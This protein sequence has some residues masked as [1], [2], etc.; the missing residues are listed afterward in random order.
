MF[1][2]V[3]SMSLLEALSGEPNDLEK[4][5]KKLWFRGGGRARPNAQD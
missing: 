5:A 2:N 4:E 1:S 3:L